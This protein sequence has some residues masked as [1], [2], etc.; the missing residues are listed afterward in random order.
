MNTAFSKSLLA[1]YLCATGAT[2][3][4]S[5]NF[6]VARELNDSVAPVALAFWRWLVAVL[7]L[8][9]FA[10]RPLIKQW[11]V[12]KNNLGYLAITAFLGVTVFNTLLYFGGQTTTALNLS[13]ISITT[14]IFI[15]IFARLFYAEAL[16]IKRVL[17]ILLVATGVVVLITRGRLSSLVNLSFTIGD[18]WMLLAAMLFALY[19]I[20]LI[21]KPE[22][23]GVRAFQLS[24]FILGFVLLLPFYAWEYTVVGP[25]VM[26]TAAVASIIYLGIFA[27]LVSYML[28]N[29]SVLLIGASRAGMVYYTIPIFSGVLAWYFLGE[30]IGL[31]HVASGLLIVAGILTANYEKKKSEK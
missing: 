1:G 2:V 24:T 17:G 7:A 29:Q 3:F 31:L 20:L 10:I 13:L 8:L 6:I 27:S 26:D 28:W 25:A 23:L 9:P 19:S 30:Q 14:P 11:P 16:T 5:G 22:N 4:W 18:V 15:I 21:K 12:V